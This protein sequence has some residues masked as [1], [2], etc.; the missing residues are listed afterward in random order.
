MQVWLGNGDGSSRSGTTYDVGSVPVSIA[1]G[2]FNH[3][4]KLDIAVAA[5]LGNGE[6]F[7]GNGDGTFQMSTTYTTGQ[8]NQV[9][10]EDVNGDGPLDLIASDYD[11]PAAL[12]VFLG[13]GDGTFGSLRTIPWYVRRS[14]PVWVTSTETV[15]QILRWPVFS[16][17]RS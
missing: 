6:V 13:R 10:A 4:K 11:Q 5:L 17:I 3:D 9:L 15:N 16:T 8:S 1:V 14:L 12:D 2:Y 7:L